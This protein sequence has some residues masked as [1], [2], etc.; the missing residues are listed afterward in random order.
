MNNL[1]AKVPYLTNQ[2]SRF[3]FDQPWNSFL[4]AQVKNKIN[5]G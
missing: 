4:G 3:G 5:G 2:V 1:P